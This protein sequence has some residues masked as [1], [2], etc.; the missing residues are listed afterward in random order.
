MFTF[1]R[2]CF[3]VLI[4]YLYYETAES[5]C[6]T[7]YGWQVGEGWRHIFCLLFVQML[8]ILVDTGK[9]LQTQPEPIQHCPIGYRW[10]TP[11][12]RWMPG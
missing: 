7:R 3:I 4:S 12:I 2:I 8:G 9:L 10:A 11:D 6:E 5:G 1:L